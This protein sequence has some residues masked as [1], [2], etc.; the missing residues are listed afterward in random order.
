MGNGLKSSTGCLEAKIAARGAAQGLRKQSPKQPNATKHWSTNYS[1]VVET[2]KQ[3]HRNRWNASPNDKRLS[4]RDRNRKITG[5]GLKSSTRCLEA[6][7]AATGA[8]QGLRKQSPKQPNTMKHQ[9]KIFIYGGILQESLRIRWNTLQNNK[10][11]IKNYRNWKHMLEMLWKIDSNR[12]LAAQTPKL[13]PEGL[14]KFCA[15][16]APNSQ[17]RWNIDQNY[18]YRVEFHK[19]HSKNDETHGK[20]I[21]HVKT[22]ENPMELKAYAKAI[23]IV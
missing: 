23:Q 4:W 18:S 16:R 6:K 3:K 17:M 13:K 14:R 11:V 2:Y 20:L 12:R 19:T 1:Y 9:S 15:S 8:A 5:N 7:I 22:C 10:K 21:K